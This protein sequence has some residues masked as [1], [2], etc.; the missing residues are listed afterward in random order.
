MSYYPLRTWSTPWPGGLKTGTSGSTD[1]KGVAQAK[2]QWKEFWKEWEKADQKL[3]GLP[4]P[5]NK[6]MSA[7]PIHFC[8]MD[9][10]EIRSYIINDPA[11]REY[12]HHVDE[13]VEYYCWVNVFPL[14]HG[15]AS[16]WVWVAYLEM[17]NIGEIHVLSDVTLKYHKEIE[18]QR[19]KLKKEMI[20]DL[21]KKTTGKTGLEKA[22]QAYKDEKKKKKKGKK[23]GFK[24]GG[25][26]GKKNKASGGKAAK[27]GSTKKK[28]K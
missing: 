24:F 20:G 15:I 11:L 19:K 9:L 12:L 26:F 7:I 2:T 27:A 3:P 28:K 16:V 8:T 14:I 23:S 22:K 18:A 1:K 10:R 25:M 6:K 21:E 17:M 4:V 5:E 13:T